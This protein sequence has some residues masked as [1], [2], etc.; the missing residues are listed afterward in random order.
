MVTVTYQVDMKRGEAALCWA[1]GRLGIAIHV[2]SDQGS[3]GQAECKIIAFCY[4]RLGMP[5]PHRDVSGGQ[6][7]NQPPEDC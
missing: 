6:I 7:S 4:G 3:Q 1:R 2:A 5:R